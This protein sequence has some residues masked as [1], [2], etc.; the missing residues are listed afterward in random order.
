MSNNTKK[1]LLEEIARRINEKRTENVKQICYMQ[2]HNF[3][4]EVHALHYKS[5]GLEEA[6]HV[7]YSMMD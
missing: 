3:I 1:K 4:A 5:K 2:D 6:L 7:V